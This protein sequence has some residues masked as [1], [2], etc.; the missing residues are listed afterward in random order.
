MWRMALFIRHNCGE[1]KNTVG[2]RCANRMR[3]VFDQM[4][5]IFTS[6]NMK[7][8][9]SSQI[10][11]MSFSIGLLAQC[12]ANKIKQ[13]V[14]SQRFRRKKLLMNCKKCSASQAGDNYGKK[15]VCS[16]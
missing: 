4:V 2:H 11:L 8:F 1:H 13:S 3:G 5:R 12:A 9:L 16:L 10:V 15:Y 6:G 7:T 14:T